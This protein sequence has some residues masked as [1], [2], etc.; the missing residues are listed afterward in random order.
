MGDNNTQDLKKLFDSLDL[1]KNG[2]LTQGELITALR[3]QARKGKTSGD[4]PLIFWGF[5]DLDDVAEFFDTADV[6][7]NKE[8]TFSE[9]KIAMDKRKS[10]N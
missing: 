7:H 9:F 2:V 8:V 1:N 10:S 5:K 4:D 6:D 3:V